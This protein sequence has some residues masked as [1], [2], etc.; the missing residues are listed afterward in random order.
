MVVLPGFEPGSPA[1]KASMI[2]HYTTGLY[3]PRRPYFIIYFWQTRRD[4]STHMSLEGIS[5]LSG[6]KEA[7]LLQV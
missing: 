2:D 5:N 6:R 7:S 3:D 4:I 1:P